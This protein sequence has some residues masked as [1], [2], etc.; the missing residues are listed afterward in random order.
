MNDPAKGLQGYCTDAELSP[1]ASEW[2]H[3]NDLTARSSVLGQL[4]SGGF[5]ITRCRS[6]A[7]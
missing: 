3:F 5:T 2:W 7:P 4:G 6:I 1:L